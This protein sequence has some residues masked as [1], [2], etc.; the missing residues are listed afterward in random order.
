MVRLRCWKWVLCL[1]LG[2]RLMVCCWLICRFFIRLMIFCRVGILKVLFR[3]VL[4]GWIVGMCLMVCRV[5]S[6]VRVKFLLN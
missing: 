6:L 5:F 4:F 2:Y 3:C 1:I